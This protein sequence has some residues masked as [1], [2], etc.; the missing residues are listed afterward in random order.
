VFASFEVNHS[1]SLLKAHLTNNQ[2]VLLIGTR[3]SL[4][5]ITLY[6]DFIYIDEFKLCVTLSTCIYIRCLGTLQGAFMPNGWHDA[7]VFSDSCVK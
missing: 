7:L 3:L 2:M 1:V 5:D 4:D 6:N